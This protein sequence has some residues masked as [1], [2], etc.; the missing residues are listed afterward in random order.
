MF[1]FRFY[2]YQVGVWVRALTHMQGIHM[3]ETSECMVTVKYVT[4]IVMLPPVV[5]IC[6]C[7]EKGVCTWVKKRIERTEA[8]VL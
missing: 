2:R 3:S 1:F 5:T 4:V 6:I 8:P 7:K